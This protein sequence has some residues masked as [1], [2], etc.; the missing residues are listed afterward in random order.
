MSYVI[1]KQLSI[2]GIYC[3]CIYMPFSQ[4][5]AACSVQNIYYNA[6]CDKYGSIF[7]VTWYFHLHPTPRLWSS[8]QNRDEKMRSN[9]QI[10]QWLGRRHLS[11]SFVSSCKHFIHAPSGVI[12]LHY[13]ITDTINRLYFEQ[14]IRERTVCLAMF[15]TIKYLVKKALPSSWSYYANSRLVIH[16]DKVNAMTFKVK[17]KNIHCIRSPATSVT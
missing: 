7:S 2:S 16:Q 8:I 14:D 10:E 4:A 1:I 9:I 15:S 17:K 13:S 5:C 12:I 6:L 3:I 11:L